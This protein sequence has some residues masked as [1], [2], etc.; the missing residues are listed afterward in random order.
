MNRE[1][2]L[3]I[4]TSSLSE[5]LESRGENIK[6]DE[7]TYLV[8]RKSVIDSIGLV[9]IIVDIEGKLLDE[10]IEITLLSEKAMSQA[11]SPFKN[12]GTLTEFIYS[13]ISES[14]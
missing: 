6:I 8:G 3:E 5:Y 10:D 7:L 4:V 9:N 13:E 1:K 11:N 2:I 14:V 12:V